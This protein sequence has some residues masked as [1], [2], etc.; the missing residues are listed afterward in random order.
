MISCVYFFLSVEYPSM[1][2]ARVPWLT[3]IHLSSFSS[4]LMFLFWE[5]SS[6][7]PN[8]NLG[9]AALFCVP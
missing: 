5:T 7:I 1:P 8:Q 6:M 9:W 2:L 3:P 4:Q